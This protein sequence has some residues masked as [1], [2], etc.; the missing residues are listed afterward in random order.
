MLLFF[1]NTTMWKNLSAFTP[2]TSGKLDVLWHDGYTFGVDGA[3]IRVLEQT[4][5]VSFARFLEGHHGGALEAQIGFEILSDLPH[6]T[7]KGKLADE[8]LGTFLVT[9]DLTQ[10]HGTRSVTVGLLDAASGGSAF[11]RRFGSQLFPGGFSSGGLACGL[12]GPGHFE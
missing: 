4:D 3:Q 8:Q 10:S 6:Q 12:L 2:N 7:L 5:Q 11:P 1:R 9:T